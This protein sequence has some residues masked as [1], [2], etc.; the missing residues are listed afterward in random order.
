MIQY[1]RDAAIYVC[2]QTLTW[3][4]AQ[5][6]YALT[7]GI[8]YYDYVKP[9]G[10]EV[11]AVF[12]ASVNDSPLDRLTLEQALDSAQPTAQLLQGLEQA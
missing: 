2:E 10:S 9:D 4:H 7:P 8:A 3:R 6:P 11:H 5:V 12:A 1:I